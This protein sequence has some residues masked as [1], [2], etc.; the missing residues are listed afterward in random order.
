MATTVDAVEELQIWPGAEELVQAVAVWDRLGA[1]VAAAVGAFDAAGLWQLEGSANLV[2]WLRSHC[3]MTAAA[4]SALAR[5]AGRMTQLPV[6]SAAAQRGALSAGQVSA[7]VARLNDT[8]V[9]TFAEHELELVPVLAPLSVSQCSRAMS[10][11]AAHADTNG[12]AP[13]ERTRFLHCS[14]TLDGRY[15]LKGS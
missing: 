9:S 11:W 10:T 1:K 4:A 3:R 15:E 8:T 13:D 14:P 12:P 5:T 2:A 6:C 7:V